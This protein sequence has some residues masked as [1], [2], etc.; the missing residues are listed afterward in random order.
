MDKDFWRL[1]WKI[2]FI[3]EK[4]VLWTWERMLNRT[5]VFWDEDYFTEGLVCHMN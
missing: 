5:K 2:T 4:K 3:P 1:Y